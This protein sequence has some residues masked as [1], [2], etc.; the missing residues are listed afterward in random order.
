MRHKSRIYVVKYFK[1]IAGLKYPDVDMTLPNLL[2]A[3]HGNSN[4]AAHS[5]EEGQR[6]PV[7]SR[8]LVFQPKKMQKDGYCDPD[9]CVCQEI[10][11]AMKKI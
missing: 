4:D 7:Y 5:V 8:G 2:T 10:M 9:C 6:K 11:E 1:D 3:A